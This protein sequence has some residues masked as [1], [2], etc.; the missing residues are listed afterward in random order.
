MA[1]GGSR[2]AVASAL[3]LNTDWRS[4]IGKDAPD[5]TPEPVEA[6]EQAPDEPQE[7]AEADS[8]P[9]TEPEPVEDAPE[10]KKAAEAPQEPEP[11]PKP[12]PRDTVPLATFQQTKAELREMRAELARMREEQ[13][14]PKAEQKPAP[15]PDDDP[16]GYERWERQ[17]SAAKQDQ[18]AR[19]V[20]EL[21]QAERAKEQRAQLQTRYNQDYWAEAE[22]DP[23]VH[24]AHQFILAQKQAELVEQGLAPEKVTAALTDYDLF[25]AAW[26]YKDNINPAKN[27]I[28]RAYAMG[29][30]PSTSAKPAPIKAEPAAEKKGNATEQLERMAEGQRK[31]GKAPASGAKSDSPLT[32]EDAL[33]KYANNPKKYR[34]WFADFR[35]KKGNVA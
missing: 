32:V 25:Q 22:K 27:L 1:E 15:D 34:E 19:E 24:E 16:E 35:A 20:Q 12:A 28:G 14:K 29:W 21:R 9:E 18:I 5:E 6:E 13:A 26:A 4:E 33:A 7:A 23:S 2:E 8:E 31:A 10:P 11:A 17:Q 3:H 30:R